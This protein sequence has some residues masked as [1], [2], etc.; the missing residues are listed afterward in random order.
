ME[1]ERLEELLNN[2]LAWGTMHDDEFIQCM[3]EASDMTIEEARE[4]DVAEWHEDRT[5]EDLGL[6]SEVDMEIDSCLADALE[7]VVYV[8]QVINDYLSDE[9]GWCVW[10]YEYDIVG[11]H[12]HITNINWDV[13]E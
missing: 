11:N 10:G 9:Y 8:E 5:G 2:I 4:L 3:V 7:D 6:P 1:K 12:I 13:S